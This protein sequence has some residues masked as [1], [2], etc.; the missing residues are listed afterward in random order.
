VK[1]AVKFAMEIV[2]AIQ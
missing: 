2:S 1:V